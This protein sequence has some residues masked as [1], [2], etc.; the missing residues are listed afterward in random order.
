MKD[1]LKVKGFLRLQMVDEDS[2]KIVGDSGWRENTVVNLG[3]QDYIVGSLGAV[4]GSKQ[5][6]HMAIGTGTA[7]GAAATS[8]EGETGARVTSSNSAVSSKTLQC[9]AQFAGS[10]MGSTCTIQNV[11]LANTS[12]GGTILCGTTYATSQWA[13]MVWRRAMATLLKVSFKFGE[14]L[15]EE[16]IPSQVFA[17]A[18]KGVETGWRTLRKGVE[19]TVRT[20][21]RHIERCRNDIV[22]ARKGGCNRGANQNVFENSRHSPATVRSKSRE[23]GEHLR[24]ETI[25]SQAPVGR[26][27]GLET[28]GTLTCSPQRGTLRKGVEEI[29]RAIWRHIE[30]SRNDYALAIRARVT[31]WNATSLNGR[32]ES[33]A[34]LAEKLREFG[35]GLSEII[36]SR[37]S[38]EAVEG[39]ETTGLLRRSLQHGALERVE[40]I[41][42]PEWRHSE[43]RRNDVALAA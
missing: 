22:L 23:F 31:I 41:V 37:A 35:G 15:R 33:V 26:G 28:R 38:A 6:S 17:K 3:F 1:M 11:A 39:V 42:R 20:I 32:V 27:E 8:L 19:G 5:V 30:R 18:I 25:P 40:D 29:V 43:R 2:G 12:A 9:T 10:D 21:W 7:P 14:H 4:A 13:L 16:T 24:E 36:P 34:T